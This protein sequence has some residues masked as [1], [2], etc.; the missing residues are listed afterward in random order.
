MTETSSSEMLISGCMICAL[1]NS[2]KIFFWSS[3]GIVE[4]MN[5][6]FLI[7]LLKVLQT[8]IENGNFFV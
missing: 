6:C 3:F 1:I 7:L 4:Y 5:E 8:Q 2:Q